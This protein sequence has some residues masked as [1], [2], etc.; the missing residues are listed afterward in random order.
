MNKKLVMLSFLCIM[1]IGVVY[2][3][4][5]TPQGNIDLKDYFNMTNL[6][7]FD[8]FSML[9]NINLNNYS[10]INATDI[11]TTKLYA[12]SNITTSGWFNG[13]YD[14]DENSSYLDFNGSILTFNETKLNSTINSTTALTFVNKS[15]DTMT[16]NL[17]FTNGFGVNASS[18]LNE[19]WINNSQEHDLN[20]NSSKYWDLLNTP[21]D[22]AISDLNSSGEV[23]LNVNSSLYW[24]GLNTPADI[25]ISNLNSSGETSLNVNSSL[26]WDNL[27]TPA[28]I[29]IS[30]LN[31]SGDE[32]LN[33]NSSDYWD[34]LGSINTT[35]LENSAGVLSI[36][37][38]WWDSLYCQLNGCTMSGNIAMSGNSITSAGAS[39]F[40]TINTGHGDNEL[41][42]M[43][44]NVT[45]TSNVTFN[46]INGNSTWQHQSYPSACPASSA[47]T[48]LGD[49]VT[50]QDLWVDEA[51]DTMTG[52]LIFS[53][54]HG[55]NASY[56]LNEPWINDTEESN[57]NVNS[58]KYWMGLSSINTTVL[59]NTTGMLGIVKSWWDSL[60]CQLNGCTMS[61]NIAMSGNS[62]TS[63]GASDFA[64]INTG[65]GDNELYAM[66]QNVT[67]TSNVVFNNTEVNGY[68]NL[69]ST[70][71]VTYFSNGCYQAVNA[72]G[73]FWVC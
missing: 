64:T 26:Y 37:K 31:I 43:N 69:T 17:I 27:N 40:A 14:W 29:A 61:G 20:V 11:N 51:G 63:A 70:G 59:S 48:Q 15:G 68:I 35:V 54:G 73:I 38:S 32:N 49:S 8:A 66:N 41:Y 60:Y 3:I 50:C 57:L 55:V 4:P 56:I 62:I 52:D 44:Q 67:T 24:D 47:I 30:D 42:A 9:G 19:P 36:V 21:A 10:I 53:A 2:A 65:H 7:Y 6:N 39:D 58:S 46:L 16:G 23:N 71:N 1:L 22:I 72:T 45:T 34:T 25:A 28:D 18:I 5:F 33:V 12:S 13:F